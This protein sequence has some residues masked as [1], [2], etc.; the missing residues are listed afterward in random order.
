L[1]SI[2]LNRIEIYRQAWNIDGQIAI[3]KNYNA[4]LVDFAEGIQKY[5]FGDFEK[6]VVECESEKTL[7]P[8]QLDKIRAL[9]FE[10][11][12]E[13]STNTVWVYVSSA[14]RLQLNFMRRTCMLGNDWEYSANSNLSFDIVKVEELEQY[15]K[16]ILQILLQRRTYAVISIVIPTNDM[17]RSIGPTEIN[18][19][20][21]TI[22][23]KFWFVYNERRC[24]K[25]YLTA[26]VDR[27]HIP[28]TLKFVSYPNFRKVNF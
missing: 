4:V 3:P 14:T 21:V 24:M 23:N 7:T 13:V 16:G 22:C 15:L 17:L 6:Q 1:E 9:Q 20:K 18:S 5:R 28:E 12:N 25:N 11:E 8:A 2:I 27:R 19:D 26:R 10:F